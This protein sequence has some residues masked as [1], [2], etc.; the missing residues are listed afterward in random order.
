MLRKFVSIKNVGRFSSYGASGDVELKRYNLIFAEN[1]R[2]KTTL[3]ALLRSLQSGDGAYLMG[4]ATL[5]APDPPTAQILTTGGMI[6]FDHRAWNATLPEIAIFDSTFV[7]ENV[8][9]GDVVNLGHR[10]SLYSVIVGK[11]GVDLAQQINVLDGRSRAKAAEI[12]EKTAAVLTFAPRGMTAETFMALEEDATIADKIAAKDREV[13]AV[14]QAA[15]IKIRAGLIS[16]TLPGFDQ[17]A[18]QGL[19]ERTIEG[20]AADADRHVADQIRNHAMHG[21]GQAWLSEGLE[22]VHGNACPF[23]SQPL[24]NA[25]AVIA[26]Y[27]AFFSAE[28]N[29]LRVLIATVRRQLETTLSDRTIADL[30]KTIDQNATS[31]E[32]WARFCEIVAPTPNGVV[33]DAL[34]ILRQVALTLLDRKAAAPLEKV[35]PDTPIIDAHAALTTLQQ[36]V[37]V[38]NQTVVAANVIIAAK[39]RTT[40]AADV[41]TVE[42][43]LTRLQTI[44]VGHEPEAREACDEYSLALLEKKAIEE[45]KAAVRRQLDEYTDQVIGRYQD[46][47]NNL[48]DVFNAGFR[49][50]GTKH[51]YP[52]GVASS[53]YQILINNTAVELGDAETPLDKPSFRNTLSAGDKSTLALAFFLAQLSHDPKKASRIVIFDDPFNSQDTFRQDCTVHKIRKCGEDCAQVIVLSHD[54]R[55]LKCVWNRLQTYTA[56]RKCLKLARIGQYDTTI[57]EWDVEKATQ[58]TYYADLKVLTD[59]A[60]ASI[61]DP[62]DVVQKIRPVLE[63]YCKYLSPTLFLET[64]WLGDIIG[65][66]RNA[67]AG[68]QLFVHCDNLDE[69][70]HY[71]KRY[72]HGHGQQPATEPI[73]DTALQGYVKRTLEFTG[74]C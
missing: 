20:V 42:A 2:G 14:K 67:G 36:A 3:C 43:A 24:D 10:R 28:Y 46:A 9:S 4:R 66:I 62:R 38:Y 22:Y 34:R 70:N 44:K 63:S 41:R 31:V 27:R 72:H 65:K 55:F 56:E 37:A 53:S 54:P 29:A 17:P 57:C 51:G 32:F 8:H 7:S 68:H 16:L 71:T 15:Q 40:G 26:A 64:D 35:E 11:Q 49:I 18:L 6:T 61:G 21:R 60:N 33:M 73:S 47:I 58:A 1:G 45:N 5:G 39:K 59:Y 69:L 48:L 74:G 13:D 50:T 25:A 30:E 52:G 12:A 23:C 19:L